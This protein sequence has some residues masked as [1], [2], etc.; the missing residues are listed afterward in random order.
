ME[1]VILTKIELQTKAETSIINISSSNLFKK[2]T[3][4]FKW[5]TYYSIKIE[6]EEYNESGK[7]LTIFIKLKDKIDEY[8]DK[9]RR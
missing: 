5:K 8:Q 1:K 2:I 7:H 3:K 6:D 4:R 9:V